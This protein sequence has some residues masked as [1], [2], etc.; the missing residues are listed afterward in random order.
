MA[1]DTT[2]FVRDY[3]SLERILAIMSI[4]AKASGLRLNKGKTEAMWLGIKGH[5]KKG[6]GL[7]WQDDSIFSLGIHF[8]KDR[9]YSDELNLAQSLERC[10]K[11]LEIWS[12]RQLS[13]IGKITV[14]KV[15]HY[16]SYYM[17]QQTFQ[18]QNH[19]LKQFTS[20]S[21]I[22]YGRESLIRFKE[23]LLNNTMKMVA[24]RW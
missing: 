15:L 5:R 19:L 11:C 10:Y 20:F 2:V 23:R 22:F 3:E 21:I 1:D 6:L 8:C 7:K 14:I 4:F 18:C 12:R 13:L 17:P 24:L 16:P 9:V